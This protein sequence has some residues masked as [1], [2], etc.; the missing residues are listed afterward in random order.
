METLTKKNKDKLNTFR[1]LPI[2]HAGYVY[3][4]ENFTAPKYFNGLYFECLL[5]DQRISANVKVKPTG[6]NILEWGSEI[7]D[8]KRF[9]VEA[10]SG[11]CIITFGT[12]GQKVLPPK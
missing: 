12:I 3:W 11:D 5:T 2:L 7:F 1:F 10:I 6:K 4:L 8:R 9:I